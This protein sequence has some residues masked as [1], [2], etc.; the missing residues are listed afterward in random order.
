M[1]SN[2]RMVDLDENGRNI[3]LSESL[4]ENLE[5]ENPEE[6]QNDDINNLIQS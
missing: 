2:Q 4:V 1:Y 5:N 3:L 6:A